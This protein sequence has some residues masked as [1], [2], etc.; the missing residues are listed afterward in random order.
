MKKTIT[1]SILFGILLYIPQLLAAHGL[2][3]KCS[4]APS[5]NKEEII[6]EV[7][8]SG[9]KNHLLIV[10]KLQSFQ[11]VKYVGKCAAQNLYFIQVDRDFQA[12]NSFLSETFQTVSLE[13]FVKIGTSSAKAISN[14]QSMIDYHNNP[15]VPTNNR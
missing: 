13:Y 12:D 8:F 11:G 15:E 6:I 3:A 4:P 1:L 9:E 2:T 7:P 5:S 14:C 10:Q